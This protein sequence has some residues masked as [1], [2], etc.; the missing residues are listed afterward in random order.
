MVNSLRASAAVVGLGQT[1]WYKRATAPEPEMKLALRAIVSAAEDAGIDTKD[2][3]GFVSWGSEKNAGQLLMTSLGMRELRYGALMWTH[4]GGSAG[5]LGLAATAIA[6]G[7]AEIVVVLR[8]MAEKGADSRLMT[9][10]WQGINPP[11]QRAN[12]MSAPAQGF[13]LD[14]SRIFEGDGLSREALWAFVRASYY[15]ANRNPNAFGRLTELDEESYL[16][17]R[18]PVEPLHLFDNSREND[19]A[20][21]LIVVPAERAKDLH[22]KPAYILSAPMGRFGG[23][24]VRDH[25]DPDGHSTAGFRSVAQRCWAESGYKPGDVNVAQFYANASTAAVKAM[26]DH[27]F[28]TW[29]NVNEFVRFENLIAP[30]GGL[31]IN[32][33]GGDLADGFIHGAGNN[34][35]AVR[36]I[37]GTSANQVPG[38]NLSLVTGGPNDSFVSTALL[39]T[40][41]TV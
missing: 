27:G 14:A 20:I 11:A 15:H 1:P 38:V 3:D 4:G 36:Q 28:C 18:S 35:E 13:A 39:G 24:D 30:D 31:P 8:A 40:E 26:I 22:A 19:C 16:T 34:A 6:T 21:A 9:A 32:T 7:Q 29:D 5:A 17:S 37:R 41:E 33:A 25:R 12:G 10:V 23:E 2:I